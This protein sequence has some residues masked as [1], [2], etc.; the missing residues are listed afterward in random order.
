MSKYNNIKGGGSVKP[1]VIIKD[2][3]SRALRSLIKGERG[4]QKSQKLPY[5]INER[6][7]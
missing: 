7:L 6:P 1:Y 3:Y 5:V 2:G 4:V